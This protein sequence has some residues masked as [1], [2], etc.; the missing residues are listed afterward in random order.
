VAKD[1]FYPAFNGKIALVKYHF[2]CA[3]FDREFREPSPDNTPK[4]P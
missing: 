4:V 1:K 2:G 3:D